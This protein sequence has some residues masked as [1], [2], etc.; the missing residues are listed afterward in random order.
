MKGLVHIYCGGG[1]GKTTCATGLAVRAAG[2]G[3]NV[4]FVYFM[5]DGQSGEAKILKKIPNVKVL[6]CSENFGFFRNMNDDTKIK[7]KTAY[8]K[9]LDECTESIGNCKNTM[10]VLD[11]ATYALKYGFIEKE[12]VLRIIEMSENGLEIVFT[13]REPQEYLLSRA[14]YITEMK[15]IRHP[16]D[17]GVSARKGIEY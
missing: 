9:L 11:E 17:K 3:M 2:S 8:S 12:K 15:C 7:A 6:Y 5:K 1:K 13:G 14:D 16:Y 4:I 10:L